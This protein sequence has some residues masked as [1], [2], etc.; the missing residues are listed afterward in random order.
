MRLTVP[1][2][3]NLAAR[4]EDI[5]PFY[6]MSLMAWARELQAQGRDIIN[7]GVGQPDFTTP[8]PIVQA[9]ITALQQGHH[10]YTPACGLPELREAISRYYSEYFAVEVAAER[11]LITPGSSG[12][13]LLLMQCLINP[14]DQVLMTDPGYPCNRNF[15][16]LVEGEALTVPVAAEDNYQLTSALLEQYWGERTKAAMI[17]SP[18]NPTGTLVEPA[19]LAQMAGFVSQQGGHLLVDEIYQGLSYGVK[20]QTAL[21]VS[22]QL[23][24]INSFSKFFGMTGW[25]LGWMV[26]P[27]QY[28]EALD[29]LAQNVYLSAPTP[30]QH[31]AL[32]AFIPETMDIL[33]QRRQQFEER[34]DY[35]IPALTQLGFEIKGHPQ[36]AF[37]LYANCRALTNDSF[38]F[39][40]RLL[41]EAGVAVTPGKDFGLHAPAQHLRF[42]YTTTLPRLQQ[43]VRRIADFLTI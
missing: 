29:R 35:L 15:V 36:G 26:V 17:A 33:E 37:Y 27:E 42:A 9:G 25:R 32:A 16:R 41:E 12:A 38:T 6:A 34:R 30:A 7:M 14:G 31:A 2:H 11:I 1:K 20:E 3:P 23:F 28:V 24:V 19:E 13:L 8:D 39:C 5:Q 40:Q 21:A 18:S 10:H 22:D 43:A 4:L